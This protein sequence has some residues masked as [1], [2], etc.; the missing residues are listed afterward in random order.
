MPSDSNAFLIECDIV[1]DHDRPLN[2]V[3][4]FDAVD[5][6]QE[7]IHRISLRQIYENNLEQFGFPLPLQN[8]AA[9]FVERHA[10]DTVWLVGI[11]LGSTRFPSKLAAAGL[12]ALT[13]V[14]GDILAETKHYKQI[15]TWAAGQ[16]DQTIEWIVDDIRQS[17]RILRKS[18]EMDVQ[19]QRA[20]DRIR[21]VVLPARR[22]TD[23]SAMLPPPPRGLFEASSGLSARRRGRKRYRARRTRNAVA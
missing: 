5:L 18:G 21:F 2:F 4:V 16:V 3:A 17:A 7:T 6:L 14:A 19:A 9:T 22:H 1:I 12:I 11:E 23:I 10:A 20:G 13:T 15:T 8:F